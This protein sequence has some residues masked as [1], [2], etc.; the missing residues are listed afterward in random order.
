MKTLT[1]P[2]IASMITFC[3]MSFDAYAKSCGADD[4]NFDFGDCERTKC[5]TETFAED[6]RKCTD[7]NCVSTFNNCVDECKLKIDKKKTLQ[8]EEEEKKKQE[9]EKKKQQGGV[10]PTGTNLDNWK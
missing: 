9:E 10:T 7:K 4:C 5:A 6:I 2:F 1:I 8:E 3:L